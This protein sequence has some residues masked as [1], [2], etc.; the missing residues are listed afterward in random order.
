MCCRRAVT[1][2]SGIIIELSA[3]RRIMAQAEKDLYRPETQNRDGGK[4][5]L[6]ITADKTEDLEF[7][8]PYYR[9]IE[10]GFRVDVATPE[11]G[12]LTAKH[13]LELK[14]TRKIA[15]L[16]PEEYDL[17]YIPGGKAPAKLK[18]DVETLEFV[19]KFAASG[20]P[21][22]AICHGPQVLAAAKVIDQRKIAAWPEVKDEVVEGGATYIDKETVV[23]GQFITA[24]WP[25]DLPSHLRHTLAAL[26]QQPAASLSPGSAHPAAA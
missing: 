19:R 24:R 4:T 17:L 23:D 22:A 16:R 13:G 26:Q 3:R 15:G 11:G 20:K 7:F 12:K 6:I 9:F 14:E 18:G 8:Y 5:I 25:G 10:A 2:H 1:Y 21:V